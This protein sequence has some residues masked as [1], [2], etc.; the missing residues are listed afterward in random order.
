[1]KYQVKRIYFVGIGGTSVSRK[2]GPAA[3]SAAGC[4][5]PQAES[6]AGSIA[7][8]ELGATQ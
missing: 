3:F 2:Q 6:A 8:T 4:D 1:M 7:R 5:R